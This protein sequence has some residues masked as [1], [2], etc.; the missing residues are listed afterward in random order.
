MLNVL[1]TGAF[2][3]IGKKL[4]SKFN[5]DNYNVV[6]W[7]LKAGEV[8][9]VTIYKVDLSNYEEV[10]FSLEQIRPD[11]IIHCA[12]SA[13][14]AK[15][16]NDPNTDFQGNVI[17]THNLLFALHK[18]NMN[19]TKFIFL[20]SAAVYG[21]PKSLP[22][23]ESDDLNP[24]SPYAVHK[25]MCESL[26]NYFCCNYKMDIKIARIFS[27]YG[28]GLRKQIFWDMHNKFRITGK[29]E[30][31]GTGCESRDYINI[32]DVIQCLY[33]ISTVKTNKMIFNVAN[34]DEITISNACNIF[35]D[36]FNIES[37]SIIF[38]GM[39]REG[40]PRNWRA[41]IS[42]IKQLGYVQ[43]INMKKGLEEYKDWINKNSL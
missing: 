39:V 23:K 33:L 6:G 27:A 15:S 18:L 35:A 3:F 5:N 21:N 9:K 4:I 41:D 22:I 26:C 31:F 11:I 43:T 17:V 10:L 30:M 40:E 37:E 38:N 42:N 25:V 16:V 8:D 12:G 20:S 32:E 28:V 34:G 29:L 19:L 7:D 13:D 14:V 1:V 24:L 36:V 2:G